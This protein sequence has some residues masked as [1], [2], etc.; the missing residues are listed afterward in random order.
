MESIN[1]T[2]G[3]RSVIPL[4]DSARTTRTPWINLSLIALNVAVFLYELWL[5]PGLDAALDRWGVVP[6]RINLVLSGAPHADLAVLVTLVTAMFLHGGWLHLAGNMLFLWIFGDNV[7]DRLGSGVYLAFYLVCGVVANLAQ[8]ES[9][10]ASLVPAIGASG[11]IAGVLGAYAVTFPGARVSVVLPILFFWVFEVPAL[12]MI[13]VWFFTQFFSGVASL[14]AAS[15]QSSDIAWWAH[16]GGFACGMV[17]MVI[18]PKYPAPT[19]PT[20]MGS[21]RDRAREDTGLI[22]LLTGL[23]RLGSQLAIFA[24]GV[25]II[26]VFLGIRSLGEF[27]APIG[28]IV[29]YT[30][31]VVAPFALYFP[32][33]DIAG[34]VIELYGVVAMISVYLLGSVAT[35]IIAAAAYEPR[36]G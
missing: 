3:A 9:A 28:L 1:T 10:P 31:P 26:A 23:V 25:R 4:G 5:G 13:G 29:R 20:W 33:Y 17:L 30:A 19:P 12:V 34:H 6:A 7:E 2:W 14:T 32:V 18:L 15:S 35:W 8:V 11:A 21:V 16:V 24:I 27:S 22:G 36:R